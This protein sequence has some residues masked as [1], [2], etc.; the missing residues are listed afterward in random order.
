M[1]QIDL[2]ERERE[3]WNRLCYEPNVTISY[4]A[5][6]NKEVCPQTCEYYK[7][8]KGKIDSVRERH[9]REL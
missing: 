5:R 6:I 3:H 9:S 4:C 8:E 2:Q 1:E 7:N